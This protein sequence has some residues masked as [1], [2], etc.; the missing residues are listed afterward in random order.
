M[1]ELEPIRMTG[2]TIDT[3]RSFRF[4]AGYLPLFAHEAGAAELSTWI[5]AR[6]ALSVN[7]LILLREEVVPP[8]QYASVGCG[9]HRATTPNVEG[10]RAR[11]S[12]MRKALAFRRSWLPILAALTFV[13]SA[14]RADAQGFISP[15][16]GYNFGGDAGCPQITDCKDKQA[17]YGV[18]FGALGSIVGFEAEVART[19]EFFG[20]SS[21]Q[22]TSVLTFMGNFMLAPKFGPIQPYGVGGLGL[23]RTSIES[24]GQ[25]DDENQ[26][27]WN[28][29]GGLI[30]FFSSHVGVRGDVRY[31]HALEVLD[32]SRFPNLPVREKKLEFN[33]FS[34][35][36]VFKF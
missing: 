15:F 24:A 4:H 5:P 19:N 28:V 1:P 21:N 16:L 31:F 34:V 7:P 14:R 8:E 9:M 32:F 10:S 29:G 2:S 12:D 23:M 36:V 18:A 33:R 3:Q 17:N 6:R 25:N 35:A 26:I 20:E 11:R 22:S 30:G 27:A 13:G